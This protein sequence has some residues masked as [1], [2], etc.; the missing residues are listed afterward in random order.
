MKFQDKFYDIVDHNKSP[1]SEK[2]AEKCILRKS[3]FHRNLP[4]HI[5]Y[6][7]HTYYM[8]HTGLL[9]AALHVSVFCSTSYILIDEINNL[10]RR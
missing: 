9:Q 2:S 6:P 8:Q 3:N 1:S 4:R 5:F 10:K 7:F